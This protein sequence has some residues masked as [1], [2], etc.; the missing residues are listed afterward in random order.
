MLKRFL[1]VSF[2]AFLALAADND[3]ALLLSGE[4]EAKAWNMLDGSKRSCMG[5]NGKPGVCMG[6]DQCSDIKGKTVG[7]CFPFDSCCSAQF[8]SCG[9]YSGASTSYFQNPEAFQNTCTYKV[10]VRRNVCQLRID[11]ER[12]S[13]SQPTRPDNSSAY[14]C[15]TDQFTLVVND[16]TKISVPVL[17]G[18]NTGQHVYV[19]IE[20]KWTTSDLNNNNNRDK[21]HVTLKFQLTARDEDSVDPEPS[22]KLKISQLECQPNSMNWWKIK[23]IARQVWDWDDEEDKDASRPKYSPAPDGCL[24]YFTDKTGTFESFNYNKGM[25]HYMGDL[26]YA[27]CFKRYSDTCGIRFKPVKFQLAYNGKQANAMDRDC[28]TMVTADPVTTVAPS[29]AAPSTAAPST[30][31]PSTAAPSGRSERRWARAA[32]DA[33]ED[34]VSKD[35]LLIPDG[36]TSTGLYG[37][38]YCDSLSSSTTV[39][40]KSQ[41]PLAVSFVSD[42]IVDPAVDVEKGFKIGYSLINSGC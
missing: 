16:N 19:P 36:R 35:Y 30:A 41:G 14:Q 28:D 18:E 13:L 39:T 34:G 23:E 10:N 25:G 12:F 26:N 11:F 9:G 21:S 7:R 5:Y 40:V 33:N 4:R 37:S 17:C 32:A 3:N 1:S 6:Q 42:N 2:L 38:K 24:Q 31:G 22:W 20:Q 15:E 8:N 27:V 29:T